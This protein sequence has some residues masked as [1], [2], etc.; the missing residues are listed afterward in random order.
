MYISVKDTAEKWGI[1]ERRVR[2]LC[3]E[4]K[5][6]GAIH[7]GRTWLIPSDATNPSD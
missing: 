7:E 6:P 1:S 5:S 4:G 3:V 2:I